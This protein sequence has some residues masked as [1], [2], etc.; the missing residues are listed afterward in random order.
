MVH[1]PRH[2]RHLHSARRFPWMLQ[3][4]GDVV[5]RYSS[6]GDAGLGED[7]GH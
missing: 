1:R 6:S 2:T 3:G 4:W 5:Q 7:M